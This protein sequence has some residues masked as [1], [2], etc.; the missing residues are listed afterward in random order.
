ME[1]PT[2]HTTYSSKVLCRNC[3]FEGKIDI[4]FGHMVGSQICPVCGCPALITKSTKRNILN[5]YEQEKNK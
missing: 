3:G 2:T 5:E 4:P 1:T